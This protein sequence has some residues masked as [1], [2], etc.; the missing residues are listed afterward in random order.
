MTDDTFTIGH[1]C[2]TGSYYIYHKN[3]LNKF[4]T[5][6]ERTIFVVYDGK[7]FYK[8]G[9]DIIYL[10]EKESEYLNDFRKRNFEA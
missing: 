6:N 7:Y 3:D 9:K 4:G 8:K 2:K 10:T 1:T 5:E